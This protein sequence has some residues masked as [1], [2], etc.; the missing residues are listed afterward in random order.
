MKK[1]FTV[2]LVLLATIWTSCSEKK[3]TDIL[4][5]DYNGK[6]GFSML[7]LPPSFVDNFV[8]QDEQ[9][10]QELLKAMK[11]FRV[12]F[13]G[14]D[15]E[16]EG[17]LPEV[18]KQISGL[19]DDHNFETYMQ[20]QKDGSSILVKGLGDDENVREM[21]VL[22]AGTGQVVLASFTGNINLSKALSVINEMDGSELDGI[23]DFSTDLNFG[24]F[25]WAF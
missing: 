11:D 15:I 3:I 24:D 22:I 13:F 2:L 1:L 4:Y 17:G 10:Q 14:Q 9:E 7:V 5:E 25:E 23:Q 16:T 19:L 12:M 20:I 21:H 18:S 6:N 8:G